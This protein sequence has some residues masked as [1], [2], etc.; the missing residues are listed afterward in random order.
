MKLF[1][2]FGFMYTFL[3]ADGFETITKKEYSNQWAFSVDKVKIG[4]EMNLP[5][6]FV[7]NDY[8]AFGLTGSSAKAVGR[9][10]DEIWIDNK[11]VKGLK[12]DL[13][14]FIKIAQS[15]C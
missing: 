4:C 7:E 9:G 10:I 3:L 14:L 13:S 1:L 5:V 15:H 2:M 12:M 6:I 8:M 11:Q